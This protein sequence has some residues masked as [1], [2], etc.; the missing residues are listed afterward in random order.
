MKKRIL[1]IEDEES[2]RKALEEILQE[3]GFET[4]SA[5]DGE[6]GLGMICDGSYDLIILDIILPKKDGFE[7]LRE[8]KKCRKEGEKKT[9][10][11]LLTNLN[12]M[13][14]IQKALDLGAKT[15]LVKTNYQL[16]DIVKKI[17][18]EIDEE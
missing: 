16:K 17:K 11:V 4:E 13:S 12:E 5:A 8:L 6:K 10:V 9:P 14:D 1:I 15:Y 3:E 7:V 18:E 2:M